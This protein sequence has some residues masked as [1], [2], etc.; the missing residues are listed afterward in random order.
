MLIRHTSGTRHHAGAIC[1]AFAVLLM[2][3]WLPG[4]SEH[5]SVAPPESPQSSPE[6]PTDAIDSSSEDAPNEDAPNEDQPK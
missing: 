3:I 6:L 1:T 2:A 4:C 5:R